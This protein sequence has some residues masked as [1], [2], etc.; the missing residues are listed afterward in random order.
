MT[1]P[2]SRRIRAF[3]LIE[4]LVV[5]AII[6]IL[7]AILIPTLAKAKMKAKRVK[8]QNNLKQLVTAYI[9][10]AHENRDRTM[11]YDGG[12]DNSAWVNYMIDKEGFKEDTMIS[13]MCEP[14]KEGGFGHKKMSWRLAA[15]GNGREVDGWKGAGNSDYQVISG[16]WSWH[17]AKADA[18]KRGGHL[19][20][21]TSEA[22]W[23]R[24][25]TKFGSKIAG[26]FMWMG[27]QRVSAPGT[28]GLP[29]GEWKW[30][31]GEPWEYERWHPSEITD[32]LDEDYLL[33]EGGFDPGKKLWS[34]HG[35]KYDQ[36]GILHKLYLLEIEGDAPAPANEPGAGIR[37]DIASSYTINAW[38]QF[39]NPQFSPKQR[40]FYT[41]YSNAHTGAPVFTEGTWSSVMPNPGDPVPTDTDGGTSGMARIY[42]DRYDA[43]VNN[44]AFMDGSVR[45]VMLSELWKLRWNARWVNPN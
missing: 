13:P 42:I 27:G 31:T 10:Y 22:E 45:S 9:S 38:A 44:V 43:M 40:R 30:V 25:V 24:I 3:T 7:A 14:N 33:L 39:G 32:G 8:S 36:H 20:A 28:K 2:K 4:L 37:R 11:P 15:G 23:N 19:A 41:R 26:K 12:S 18:E 5:I 1:S 35:G 6:G 16:K 34:D 17:K 21:I 29:N